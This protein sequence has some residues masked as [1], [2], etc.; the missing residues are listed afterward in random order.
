MITCI[1][2]TATN[3]PCNYVNSTLITCILPRYP[4]TARRTLRITLNG[5]ATGAIPPATPN[6]TQFTFFYPCTAGNIVQ[7]LTFLR[8][9]P[10]PVRQ[11]R[12]VWSSTTRRWSPWE[13][14][15]RAPGTTLSN[16][17]LVV[18]LA[19]NLERKP[20]HKHHF[21]GVL[22]ERWLQAMQY[23]WTIR[24]NATNYTGD[25]AFSSSSA[26]I[27]I[28]SANL[29]PSEPYIVQLTARNFLG[30]ND[31][32]S[33][34][35][36]WETRSAPPRHHT[37][38]DDQGGLGRPGGRT[39]RAGQ[40]PLSSCPPQ[41]V[42]LGHHGLIHC[43]RRAADP[44]QQ[45]PDCHRPSHPSSRGHVHREADGWLWVFDG[46]GLYG[47]GCDSREDQGTNRR[48]I[49]SS[50]V[51]QRRPA[52]DGAISVGLESVNVTVS[53]DCMMISTYPDGGMNETDCSDGVL[54][55]LHVAVPKVVLPGGTLQTGVYRFVLTLKRGTEGSSWVQ[56]M[57][58]VQQRVPTV[59]VTPPPNGD[60]ALTSEEM[61][62]NATIASML[63]GTARW[64]NVYIQGVPP[65]DP[66]NY[67]SPVNY[68]IVPP[69][70]PQTTTPLYISNGSAQLANQ[71]S[72]ALRRGSLLPNGN[73]TSDSGKHWTQSRA[74]LQAAQWLDAPA[75]L[76][77]SYQFGMY[78][79]NSTYLLSGTLSQSYL[80]VVLP[81]LNNLTLFPCSTMPP[82]CA[83]SKGTVQMGWPWWRP[84]AAAMNE[85]PLLFRNLTSL[86]QNA[87]QLALSVT[88][89]A[90]KA[91]LNFQLSVVT[92][93]TSGALLPVSTYSSAV[94]LLEVVVSSYNSLDSPSS[95]QGFSS[96]EAN[97]V[98]RCYGNLLGANFNVSGERVKSN[99]VSFSLTKNINAIG[100]GLCKQLGLYQEA[101]TLDIGGFGVLKASLTN[102]ESGYETQCSGNICGK[103]AVIVNFSSNLSQ[104][105]RNWTCT[106][107]TTTSC[108]GC[109]G[110]NCSAI[111]TSITLNP[112]SLQCGYWNE[113]LSS[114]STQGC[115]LASV[116]NSLATCNCT[117]LSQFAV[118][119]VCPSGYYGENCGSVCPLG[120][121][122]AE[123]QSECT[124]SNHGNCVPSNG[125][126]ICDPGWT[127]TSCNAACMGT[128][129]D[130]C[131]NKCQC[132][133]GATCDPV[134]GYCNC[135]A[136][137]LGTTC[138]TAC[139]I[140][141][142][143]RGCKQ[144]C[145]CRAVQ[146]CNK[147]TG[148]CTCGV[149]YTG[150]FCNATCP[151]LWYGVDC[152]QRCQCYVAGTAVC[153][154]FD[155]RCNCGAGWTGTLCDAKIPEPLVVQPFPTAAVV[156]PLLVVALVLAVTILTIAVMVKN[157][158]KWRKK[159]YPVTGEGEG[160]QGLLKKG[161]PMK[162][163][164]GGKVAIGGEGG[165]G[166]SSEGSDTFLDMT[167][168]Y[169][170]DVLVPQGAKLKDLF[171]SGPKGEE[172][173][174]PPTMNGRLRWQIVQLTD[175]TKEDTPIKGKKK[176]PSPG[177]PQKPATEAGKEGEE[178]GTQEGSKEEGMEEVIY[179]RGVYLAPTA[180]LRDLRNGFVETRQTSL[181]HRMFLFLRSDIL[182]DHFDISSEEGTRLAHIQ[183][184][185]VQ[186]QTMYI[187]SLPRNVCQVDQCPCGRYA[188][189]ECS[190][191]GRRGYCGVQCQ[192]EDWT[193][194]IP[195]C[196][197]GS[198]KKKKK[199]GR[200][201]TPNVNTCVCGKEADF[202][203]KSSK[204]TRDFPPSWKNLKRRQAFISSGDSVV[205]SAG[206]VAAGGG[207]NRLWVPR[208]TWG[209]SGDGGGGG[210]GGWWWWGGGGGA[211]SNATGGLVTLPPAPGNQSSVPG[212]SEATS[213]GSEGLSTRGASRDH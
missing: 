192:K 62:I 27:S 7:L 23:W 122:G 81:P 21:Q 89:P 20:N 30:Y 70:S 156:V 194:H 183:G 150:T 26:R 72:L 109:V 118:V 208:T 47:P 133:N 204:T 22:T 32:T 51:R 196:T 177:Q 45:P 63:P 99:V 80:N 169:S 65:F 28:P 161:I 210:G 144:A 48:W 3:V 5:D 19:P 172:F 200:E 10:A 34:T 29:S 77:L 141:T 76:P 187:Q 164:V 182:G 86:R 184:S 97:M 202:E 9:T 71:L 55:L 110:K 88:L 180:T 128:W 188:E 125:V 127:G 4:I 163:I 43:S 49:A 209:P 68:T 11:G 137:W 100:Y 84:L 13:R 160:S 143:G 33:A 8:L 79:G 73:S 191:C 179:R 115:N 175:S 54:N 145:Q 167:R 123:C 114:W 50:G 87:L 153:S 190:I 61:I 112:N 203:S 90:T 104:R 195:E 98:L 181:E 101:K 199:A 95:K 85:A 74:N 53:W 46:I 185:L 119:Q 83:S 212:T 94:A 12:G 78:C 157:K 113:A 136:G 138:D 158:K 106:S 116:A 168:A 140:G 103:S 59:L 2:D 75:Y 15:Q 39:S 142:Y 162:T 52:A 173:K 17:S 131:A 16:G 14:M 176:D 178:H 40:H 38:R 102:L 152:Q 189:M 124:C 206:C 171:P 31:T 213:S 105:Y 129:G 130:Q 35:L 60:A 111:T 93:L 92:A 186:P 149:G 159:V 67:I 154:R 41:R 174:E 211:Q 108:S 36:T 193:S 25:L 139:P 120:L 1:V 170:L 121:W 57:T 107:D 56:D 135:T 24:P 198:K 126:C 201:Y 44:A 148:V 134:T 64:T 66:Q 166:G 96:E 18:N 58:V 205:V 197:G 147:T 69:G 117:H 37:G 151:S 42:P 207:G 91:F 82:P 155:G 146:Q 132:M 165:D 6:A